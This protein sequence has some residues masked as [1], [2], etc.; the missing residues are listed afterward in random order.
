MDWQHSIIDAKTL[1]KFINQNSITHECNGEE[2]CKLV[3]AEHLIDDISDHL[4][5]L[6]VYFDPDQFKAMCIS[7]LIKPEPPKIQVL[8]EDQHPKKGD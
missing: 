5:A 2:P 8:R 4:A 6:S 1:A 3:M 7:G